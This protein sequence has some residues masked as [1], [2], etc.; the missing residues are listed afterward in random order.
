VLQELG[1]IAAIRKEAKD[2][3]KNSQVETRVAISDEVGRLSPETETALYRIVQEALHNVAKH[4]QASH[5]NVV[6][7]RHDDG[8][9][10]LVEDDGDR[11]ISQEQFPRELIWAGRNQRTCR[12]VRW[13]GPG[14]LP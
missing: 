1:L 5:V 13:Q 11:N 4:A 6:M 3:E 2:L 12:N 8:I 14:G 9:H 10:L 7:D